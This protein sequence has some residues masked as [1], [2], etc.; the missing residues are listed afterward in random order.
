MGKRPNPE[1]HARRRAQISGAA[2]K[3]F[4]EKGYHSAQ[5]ADIAREL[6]IG[7]GTVYRYFK[8]KRAVFI[9]V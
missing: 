3:V 2:R 7:H 4:A 8:D 6:E 9:A 1:L 5:I